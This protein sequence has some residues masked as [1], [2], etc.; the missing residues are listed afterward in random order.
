MQTHKQGNQHKP[1]I[2][3]HV[4]QY[5]NTQANTEKHIYANTKPRTQAQ[6]TH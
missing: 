2:N 3:T 6:T 5:S 4:E 1:H